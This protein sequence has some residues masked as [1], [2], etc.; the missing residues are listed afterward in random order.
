MVWGGGEVGANDDS[1]K[2]GPLLKS[3]IVRIRKRWVAISVI[4]RDQK[5]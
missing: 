2:R 1:K 5:L 4:A 3:F